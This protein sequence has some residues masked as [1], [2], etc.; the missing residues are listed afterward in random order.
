MSFT[1]IILVFLEGILAFISPCILPMLPIYFVYLSGQMPGKDEPTDPKNKNILLVNTV[2]FTAGFTLIFMIM[3]LMGNL[4]GQIFTGRMR[5]FEIISG[6]III[7]MGIHISGLI[8]IKALQ[9]DK[10]IQI[11]RSKTGRI[12][13]LIL[14]SAF[15]L[16]WSPCIGPF[17]GA[18]ILKAGQTESMMQGA[19]LLFFFALGLAIPF[20][21]SA[22]LFDQLKPLLDQL[23]KN[24]RVIRIISG[25]L[26]IILGISMLLGGFSYLTQLIV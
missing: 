15:A 8:K 19:F 14:G 12:S 6:I 13:S 16:G 24:G 26:L 22:L 21:L 1:L 11:K 3:G 25:I 5:L 7:L 18:A 9:K 23:K 20:L 4:I 10:R 2:F 17:L